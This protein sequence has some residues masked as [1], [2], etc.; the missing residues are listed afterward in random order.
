M[1]FCMNKNDCEHD[2]EL[3]REAG[4]IVEEGREGE[5]YPAVFKCANCHLIL[6]AS[7]A[8]QFLAVTNQNKLTTYQLGFQRNMSVI[9]IILSI[10]AI[11]VSIF[12]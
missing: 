2:F 6:T 1:L 4:P 5:M 7:E 10:I 12:R 11:V 8:L 9:A 3:F